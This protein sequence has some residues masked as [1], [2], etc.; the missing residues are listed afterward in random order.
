MSM[1]WL[2]GFCL[3]LGLVSCNDNVI[4]S[5]TFDESL[6]SGQF[7]GGAKFQVIAPVLVAKCANCHRHS[8]WS[9]Y[10]ELDYEEY[11][12][13]T[14]GSLTASSVYYRLSNAVEGP[15]SR[16]MP[17]GGSPPLTD[18]ELALLTGW[19]NDFEN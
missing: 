11:G 6:Y 10:S 1:K 12:L 19:I 18:A 8:D 5:S 14:R 16:N 2:L 17:Q 13:V 7:V 4:N 3:I 15:G 9:S